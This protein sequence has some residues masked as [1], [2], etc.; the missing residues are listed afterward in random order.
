MWHVDVM[1]CWYASAGF[2]YTGLHEGKSVLR[3]IAP[4]LFMTA[5]GVWCDAY[6][7]DTDHEI[8]GTGFII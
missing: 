7:S 1:A 4:A 5:H 6:A 2:V 3:L 8:C